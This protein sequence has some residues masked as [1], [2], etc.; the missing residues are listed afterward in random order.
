MMMFVNECYKEKKVPLEYL[1]GFLKLLNP[2][3]PHITEELYSQVL[4]HNESIAYAKWPEFDE[5]KVAL[6]KATII[7]Q[8]NGKMRDKL[9]VE[10]N[11]SKETVEKK[12]LESEKVKAFIN[13]ASVKKVIVV[14]NKL[15]NIVI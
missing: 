3:A 7:V 8:V 1:E 11:A 9:E 15:V 4:N 2:I 13:G 5:N 12:A 6:E 14:P 10:M